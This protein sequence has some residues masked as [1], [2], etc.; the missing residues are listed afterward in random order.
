MFKKNIFSKII[1]NFLFQSW[2]YNPVSGS[3]LGQNPG[4]GSKFN[5]FGSTT[6]VE[7]TFKNWIRRRENNRL[8]Q[9]KASSWKWTHY[10]YSFDM[11]IVPKIFW[12]SAEI[13]SQSRLKQMQRNT[14][15]L[16]SGPD[17][18]KKTYNMYTGTVPL[19]L[20]KTWQARILGGKS[21]YFRDRRTL[22]YK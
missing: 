19:H 6:L 3:E 15:C 20:L 21:D 10:S 2:Y 16:V 13:P 5:V 4:S 1:Q 17:M 14:V 8:G 11:F 12:I 22:F 18:Y 9:K 7:I